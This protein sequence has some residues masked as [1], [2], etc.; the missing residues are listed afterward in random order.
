MPRERPK[1]SYETATRLAATMLQ[2]S[3]QPWGMSFDTIRH[4]FS[5]SERTLMRYEAACRKKCSTA[6]AGLWSRSCR[7][8]GGA[9]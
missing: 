7:E 1:P 6:P 4:R 2:L 9:T 3:A 8:A 5:I